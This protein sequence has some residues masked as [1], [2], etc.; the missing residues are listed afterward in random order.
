MVMHPDIF[1]ELGYVG[2]QLGAGCEGD[3]YTKM[4]RGTQVRVWFLLDKFSGLTV[5]PHR[6]CAYTLLQRVTAVLCRQAGIFVVVWKCE[7]ECSVCLC[8]SIH[9]LTPVL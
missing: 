8:V 2:K 1:S 9:S 7:S 4:L 3:E 6:H 5:S